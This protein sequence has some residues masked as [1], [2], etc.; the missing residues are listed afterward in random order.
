VS[1]AA[2]VVPVATEV[3]G[4]ATGLVQAGERRTRDALEGRGSTGWAIVGYALGLILLYVLI[5]DSRVVKATTKLVGGAQTATEAWIKPVDPLALLGERFGYT[6]STP[7]PGSEAPSGSSPAGVRS[8]LGAGTGYVSPF[9]AKATAGRTDQGVDFSAPP[10]S[11][12]LAIG[13]A[14][15]MGIE[16]NW[17]RGQPFIYY[18]LLDGPRAGQYVYA[19]EQIQP[20]VRVG[21]IVPAG[22]PIGRVARS[23]TGL[24][25]GFATANGATLAHSTTGYVEGRATAAGDAFRSFLGL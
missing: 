1:A 5:A 20:T 10:G 18:K 11:S 14:K 4:R 13:R 21:Q 8:K 25:L 3:A 6:P 7:G 19:A 16:Q 17:Y 12:V 9:S 23:G 22:Q 24:E 2:V 15:I